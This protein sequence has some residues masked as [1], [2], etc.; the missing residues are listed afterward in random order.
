MNYRVIEDT[1]GDLVLVNWD[2]VTHISTP[3]NYIKNQV[4]D[5]GT[6]RQVN[7]TNKSHIH[8]TETLSELQDILCK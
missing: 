5:N 1:K 6:V 8:T 3:E 7:F 2:K 4:G